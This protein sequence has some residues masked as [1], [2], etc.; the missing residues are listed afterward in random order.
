[1][2][3]LA[4][5]L[6]FML[7][8]CAAFGLEML[9]DTTM[10]GITGQAGVAIAVDDIQLF[11]NIEKLA[12]ID[13]DGFDSFESKGSCTGE[14]GAIALNNFQ[15][16]VLN[17]NAITRTSN[18]S[19]DGQSVFNTGTLG[20]GSTECG[21]IDL[22]Y[23][24]AT[25]GTGTGCM[26]AG[27]GNVASLGLNNYQGKYG[28]LQAFVPHFLTID[29]TDD[30]PASTSGFQYWLNHTWTVPGIAAHGAGTMTSLGGVLIGIPT[31]EI[32]I[33][34]MAMTPIY[35]GDLQGNASE[36]GNDDSVTWLDTTD[37][38][39]VRSNTY[40]TIYMKGITF[41]TLSGWIEIAPK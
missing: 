16:D 22:F 32:Y 24:Y 4:L 37:G 41:T 6:A 28:S 29:V 10:D 26:L 35:D 5:I 8:P 40:G 31:V 13:C 15:I 25:I 21:E 38:T 7:I 18:S 27:A 17:I 14:G 23:N 30:L 39:T 9:S 12:W 36:A 20:L 34:E 33:N 11:L 2:K 3:K 19:N 1:M